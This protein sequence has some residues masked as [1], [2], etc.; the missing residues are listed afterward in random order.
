[1]EAE[2]CK[3]EYEHDKVRTAQAKPLQRRQEK[4]R[5]NQ[6]EFTLINEDFSQQEI[7]EILTKFTQKPGESLL[8]WM[9][10]IADA[11]AGGN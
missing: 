5:G 8:Q 10:R 6:G 3:Y 4:V 11:G 9:V 7:S 2:A 1:M